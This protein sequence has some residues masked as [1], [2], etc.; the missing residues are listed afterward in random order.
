MDEHFIQ[1]LDQC[2]T[3]KELQNCAF[4]IMFK[5]GAYG[6]DTSIARERWPATHFSFDQMCRILN[7]AEWLSVAIAPHLMLALARAHNG[8]IR[9]DCLLN[10]LVIYLKWPPQEGNEP[11]P[12]SD[13]QASYKTA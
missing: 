6:N 11:F 1:L 7:A 2:T 10:A 5:G 12:R 13:H 3:A 4:A 8:S 9:F